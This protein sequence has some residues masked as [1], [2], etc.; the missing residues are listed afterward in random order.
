[1]AAAVIIAYVVM[2]GPIQDNKI[3]IDFINYCCTG[4]IVHRLLFH[5]AFLINIDI[6]RSMMFTVSLWYCFI[7]FLSSIYSV[8]KTHDR[9][10]NT[11]PPKFKQF[12]IVKTF[13]TL[14]N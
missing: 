5:I 12:D 9:L 10:N 7:L 11:I 4:W 14:I 1:M 2:I 3:A 8:G 6:L 13:K